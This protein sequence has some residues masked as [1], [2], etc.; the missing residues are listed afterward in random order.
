MKSFALITVLAAV[1]NL[2]YVFADD[3]PKPKADSKSVEGTWQ[4]ALK[5]G[6]IERRL[7]FKISKKK[8]GTLTTTMDSLDQGAKDVPVDKVTWKEP[9]LKMELKVPGNPVFEGKANKDLTEIEGKWKQS[10]QTF[11]LTIKRVEKMTELKRP[12]EPKKPY[13]YLEEEVTYENPRAGV[14]LA[15]TLTLPKGEG[16]FPAVLLIA[17][18]GPNSRDE[19]VF[20]HKIFLVLADY[21]TRRGVVVLRS[22]KRGIGKST[23]KYVEA[24]SADF[25][26]DALAGVEYLKTR[27]EVDPHKIGLVGHSEGGV[28]API[29]AS[30]SKDV[31]FI[32]LMAGTGVNGEQVLYRQGQDILK[33]M[34]TDAKT[35]A[36]Q[37]TVQEKM[38]S[39]LQQN[40]DLKVAEK[41]LNEFVTQEIAKLSDEEKKT[42]KTQETALDAQVKNLLTP[43]M[44][45]FLTFDPQATLGL[46]HCP[47]LA[48]NGAKDL[49]VAADVNL[50]AIE[51]ALRA[52]GNQ[53]VT[54][55]ELPNLNHL[56][57]TSKTGNIFEYGQIEET[58]SPTALAVMGDWIETQAHK[59]TPAP[60]ATSTVTTEDQVEEDSPRLVNRLRFRLRNMRLR[61]R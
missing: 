41:K 29:V 28:V 18:S 45:Y 17:G 26:D 55:K 52:G 15:G 44:R 20:G 27:K 21:L 30:R 49:Q 36:R 34:G 38:F 10:G 19:I 35:L 8:D 58:I 53:D 13:P 6:V 40:S 37:R 3:P 42:A 1:L 46:V 7:A 59:A 23:G 43:W 9:D 5:V 2:N 60:A 31:A 51:K 47:V 25:A 50:P 4:G 39:I 14:K 12:Q 11:P 61:N 32:V 16:P 56:F 33:A 24:T 57:Q 22:D 54:V 48:I